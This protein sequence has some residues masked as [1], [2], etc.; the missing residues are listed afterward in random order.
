MLCTACGGAQ[1]NSWRYFEVIRS[2]KRGKAEKK[3][4]A[5]FLHIF[6]HRT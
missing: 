1:R 2:E 4:R 6:L 5:I 3:K